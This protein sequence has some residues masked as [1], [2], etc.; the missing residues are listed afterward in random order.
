M[1]ALQPVLGPGPIQRDSDCRLYGTSLITPFVSSCNWFR[2][3]ALDSKAS[4]IDV[5]IGILAMI[6]TS[7]PVL[8]GRIVQMIHYG[9]LSQQEREKPTEVFIHGQH[10]SLPRDLKPCN[11]PSGNFYIGEE[12]DAKEKLDLEAALQL[13][14]DYLKSEKMPVILVTSKENY[15]NK[16]HLRL[17]LD[18]RPGEV[19][20][21]DNEKIRSFLGIDKTTYPAKLELFRTNGYRAIKI[22]SYGSES[23]WLVCDESCITIKNLDNGQEGD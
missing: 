19:A 12:L 22:E 17:S 6:V 10:F 18:L 23:R 13:G 3:V 2:T 9:V 11:L 5:A 14:T 7:V 4:G 8:I 15:P 16:R 1:Q 20:R 21:Y